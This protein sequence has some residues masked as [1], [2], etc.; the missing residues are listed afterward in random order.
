MVPLLTGQFSGSSRKLRPSSRG[1]LA[2]AQTA[3][4]SATL[5]PCFSFVPQALDA[6]SVS[7]EGQVHGRVVKVKQNTTYDV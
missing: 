1:Q 5:E 3:W 2:G 4:P 6:P 7:M